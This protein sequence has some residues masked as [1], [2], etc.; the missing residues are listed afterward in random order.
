MELA[1]RFDLPRKTVLANLLAHPE[2][3]QIRLEAAATVSASVRSR[4]LRRISEYDLYSDE[5]MQ[6]FVD[7]CGVYQEDVILALEMFMIGQPR[8]AIFVIGRALES[9]LRSY[10]KRR[11]FK[12][13]TA[14][15]KEELTFHGTIDALQKKKVLTAGTAQK[16]F[17]LKWDRNYGGHPSTQAEIKQLLQSSS[18]MFELGVLLIK[19]VLR[20]EQGNVKQI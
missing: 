20:L 14:K 6:S 15:K 17:S 3:G 2:G 8:L 19:D 11:P 13:Y 10:F 7:G 5:Q 9:A 12:G 18:Q 4:L 1:K 16:M